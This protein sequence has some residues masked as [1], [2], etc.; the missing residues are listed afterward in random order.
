[1]I[2]Y[3]FILM[4]LNAGLGSLQAQ[5]R[6]FI[7]AQN[8]FSLVMG[9]ENGYRLLYKKGLALSD[10]FEAD[11]RD[12]SEIPKL[13]Y[14]LGVDY[15]Q[16]LFKRFFIKTGV[17]FAQLGY[18]T[19]QSEIVWPSEIDPVTGEIIDDPSL[20]QWLL[21]K[22]EYY[23]L[24]IPLMLRLHLSKNKVQPFVGLG[25]SSHIFL[26]A[27]ERSLTDQGRSIRQDELSDYNAIQFSANATLGL[28]FL[29]NER[30]RFFAQLMARYHLTNL[31]Q[32]D[33]IQEHLYNYG[34]EAGI[35]L[36]I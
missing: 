14:R 4:L 33:P 2:R 20:P 29:R 23:F 7:T 15:H 31:I 1:M 30:L 13:N 25:L 9:V 36:G 5:N 11:T 34:L 6:E 10:R 27:Q 35:R 28:E 8:S 18:R 17:R 26:Y 19:P 16:R 22:Y 21:I 12:Q 32:G 24:E 3:L